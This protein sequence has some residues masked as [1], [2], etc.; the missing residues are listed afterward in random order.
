MFDSLTGKCRRRRLGGF[1]RGKCKETVVSQSRADVEEKA[2]QAMK[3]MSTN[4]EDKRKDRE[5]R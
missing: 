1:V 4:T 2:G 5:E 3:E